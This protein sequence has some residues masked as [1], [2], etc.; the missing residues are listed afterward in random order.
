[1][2]FSIYVQALVMCTTLKIVSYSYSNIDDWRRQCQ[3]IFCVI[4]RSVGGIRYIW[5]IPNLISWGDKITTLFFF[6]TLWYLFIHDWIQ[7]NIKDLVLFE[8]F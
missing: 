4:P 6:N 5:R 3:T 7:S 8:Y 1:M 2:V